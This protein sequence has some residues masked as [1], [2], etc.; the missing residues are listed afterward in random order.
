MSLFKRLFNKES[1]KPESSG[2]Q[3]L[4]ENPDMKDGPSLIIMI[5]GDCR[6]DGALWQSTLRA[7]DSEMDG[8]RVELNP[9][10]TAQG[11]SM[12]HI[13]WGK[14][15][16]MVVGFNAPLPSEVVEL[17][18]PP[19]HY[20]EEEKDRQRAGNCGHVLLYYKGYETAPLEQYVAIAA[21]AGTLINQGA[22]AVLNES[23][24]T[25]LPAATLYDIGE[26]CKCLELLRA[27]PIPL[28]YAGMVKYDVEDVPGVWMRTFANEYWGISNFARLA[29]GHHQ[30]TETMAI[31]S[32]L[33]EHFSKSP[34][35]LKPGDTMQIGQDL[36]LKARL[37]LD[38]EQFLI[39]DEHPLL[40]LDFISSDE[41]NRLQTTFI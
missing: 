13:G 15:V 2:R 34:A 35:P 41:I 28:L 22:T 36:W 40:V 8:A 5:D 18:L 32:D 20:A 33:I 27:L 39:L 38:D 3:P 17:C 11:L 4:V 30:G 10:A 29:E 25:A 23:A 7:F 24:R 14:H 6:L 21:V 37:P 9:A 1:V 26:D 19:A 16:V 31:F 12:G